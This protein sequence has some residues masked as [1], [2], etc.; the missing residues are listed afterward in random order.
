MTRVK[1][2]LG[3]GYER[4]SRFYDGYVNTLIMLEE[5]VVTRVL[6]D[7]RGKRVLD[8]AC[9][10]GR[11]T[12]AMHARGADVRGIDPS[13][14][15]LAVARAKAPAIDFREGRADAIPEPDASFDIVLC[16][17]LMEHLAD[18]APALAEMRRVLVLGGALVVSVYHP[19]FL[20]RGVPPHFRESDG[21][22]YELPW[23]VHLPSR[24][25]EVLASLGM[26]VT[27]F[28]EPTVDES[29]IARLPKMEKYRGE[30]H[31]LVL[32]AVR[33]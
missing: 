26:R 4:W 20:M 9:G 23:H 14:A 33:A 3:E 12:V 22:E 32:R 25:F 19:W 13:P 30:P 5:P 17:L 31:A 18:V 1:V 11:H 16:A 6:G 15:M 28:V 2:G 29:L 21:A 8:V 27:D 7:L 10:T 24:Y